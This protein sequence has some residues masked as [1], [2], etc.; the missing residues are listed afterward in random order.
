MP[1]VE[2]AEGL[3][4]TIISRVSPFPTSMPLCE[5]IGPPFL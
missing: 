3:T 1:K 5:S 4:L 2:L